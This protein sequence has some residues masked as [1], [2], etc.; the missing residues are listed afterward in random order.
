MSRKTGLM[1]HFP[2]DNSGKDKNEMLSN[3]QALFT[4]GT[5]KKYSVISQSENLLK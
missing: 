4:I 2:R 1:I 3:E 5:K